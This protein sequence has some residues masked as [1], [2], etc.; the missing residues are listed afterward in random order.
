MI[1]P[2]VAIVDNVEGEVEVIETSLNDL[3][4][5]YQFFNADPIEGEYPEK[6]IETIELVFL[7]LFYS[8]DSIELDPFKPAQWVDHIV[9]KGKQYYLIILSRDIHNAHSVLEVLTEIGKPPEVFR[10]QRKNMEKKDFKIDVKSIIDEMRFESQGK[11]IQETMEVFAEIID[12]Q[13]DHILLNCLI[14]RENFVFQV[15]RFDIGIFLNSIRL[16]QGGFVLVKTTTKV[17]S[18][19]FE[20][21]NVDED[22][23][24][25]FDRPDYFDGLGDVSFL[26]D[27]E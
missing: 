20:I 2:Q 24:N 9:P 22:L 17:G 11:E 15:R 16:N 26:F 3:H 4:V 6:P 1:G 14:D 27:K 21:I 10:L 19:L 18:R 5:G 25:L 13:E 12:I 7:D 8:S 23:R